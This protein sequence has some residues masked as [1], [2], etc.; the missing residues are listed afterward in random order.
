MLKNMQDQ[1]SK[2][3]NDW[4]VILKEEIGK[5]YFKKIGQF[6]CKEKKNK[7]IFPTNEKIFN[8]L[9]KTAFKNLSL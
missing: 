9:K 3:Q 6:I 4:K 8:S 1:I 7:T 5:E 2:I